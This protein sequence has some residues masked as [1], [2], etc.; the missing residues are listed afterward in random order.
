ML[1][2]IILLSHMPAKIPHF[3]KWSEFNIGDNQAFSSVEKSLQQICPVLIHRLNAL[4]TLFQGALLQC[5][6][7]AVVYFFYTMNMYICV[8]L[9]SQNCELSNST[10]HVLKF[11]LSTFSKRKRQSLVY[12]ESNVIVLNWMW[13]TVVG[14]LVKIKRFRWVIHQGLGLKHKTEKHFTNITK[15]FLKQFK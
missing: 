10:Y 15:S 1:I 5:V 12:I 3:E 8:H 14:I 7:H 4:L 9:L 11:Q 2:T 13:N 6:F